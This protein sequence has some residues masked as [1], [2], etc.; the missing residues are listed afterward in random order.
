MGTTEEVSNIME[1]IV[2]KKVCGGLVLDGRQAHSSFSLFSLSVWLKSKW[3]RRQL[4]FQDKDKDVTIAVAGG[5]DSNW[6]KY[7]LKINV[8]T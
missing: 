7:L 5:V 8:N 1:K 6:A 4:V 2:T 3:N